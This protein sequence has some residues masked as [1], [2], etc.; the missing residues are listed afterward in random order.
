[1]ETENIFEKS[2]LPTNSQI[3]KTYP[4][5]PLKREKYWPDTLKNVALNDPNISESLQPNH[6]YYKYLYIVLYLYIRLHFELESIRTISLN[7][8][9]EAKLFL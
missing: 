3:D 7:T 1:M 5:D 8:D 2:F 6:I 9:T 4:S